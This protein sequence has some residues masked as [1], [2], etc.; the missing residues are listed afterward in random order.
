MILIFLAIIWMEVKD[1]TTIRIEKY[2]K[3][4]NEIGHKI[5]KK[6]LNNALLKVEN[7]PA[8]KIRDKDSEL[9]KIKTEK[10]IIKKELEKKLKEQ[11]KFLLDRALNR[12][13]YEEVKIYV[14]GEEQF[15]N[16]KIQMQLI[17]FKLLKLIPYRMI[18]SV[19]V[20]AFVS[21]FI[22]YTAQLG[23]HKRKVFT[24]KIIANEN[25]SGFSATTIRKQYNYIKSFLG[26]PEELFQ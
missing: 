10:S 4:C 13:K 24:Q 2:I 20:K 14:E 21:G 22:Y 9:K 7:L 23:A 17:A 5:N 8:I 19:N 26:E 6:M 16:L 18:N 11:I 15:E 1:I 3:F 12:I 25:V